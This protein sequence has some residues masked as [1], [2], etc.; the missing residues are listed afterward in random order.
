MSHTF[1]IEFSNETKE[2]GIENK[3][4]NEN[5]ELRIENSFLKR[6]S[7]TNEVN[8]LLKEVKSLQIKKKIYND[9]VAEDRKLIWL[10]KLAMLLFWMIL[11]IVIYFA[12][13]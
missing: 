10:Y 8:K 5:R 13:C 2:L 9:M 3:L 12:F 1:K 11:L 7:N 4:L 6:N